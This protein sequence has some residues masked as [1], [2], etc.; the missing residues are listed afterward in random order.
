MP[1]VPIVGSLVFLSLPGI[2]A[3]WLAPGTEVEVSLPAVAQSVIL[4]AAIVWA[5]RLWLSGGVAVAF[6][7]VLI[8]ALFLLRAAEVALGAVVGRNIDPLV[9][10]HI[11]GEAIRVALADHWPYAA[12]Q[13]PRRVLAGEGSASSAPARCC[14]QGR[15]RAPARSRWGGRSRR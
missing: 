9:L 5:P 13:S 10:S 12:T 4:I 15:S 6:S 14:W 3:V 1:I 2:V 7:F 11:D 8:E